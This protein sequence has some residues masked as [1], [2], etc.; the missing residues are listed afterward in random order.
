MNN[1]YLILLYIFLMLFIIISIVLTNN[2][3]KDRTF[4]FNVS[5]DDKFE[6]KKCQNL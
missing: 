4:Y 2:S 1:L 5:N 6:Y 3:S